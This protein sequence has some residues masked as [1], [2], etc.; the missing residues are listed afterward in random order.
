VNRKWRAYLAGLAGSGLIAYFVLGLFDG[1]A[2][3]HGRELLAARRPGRRASGQALAEA[4]G[5]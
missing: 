1:S 3:G 2:A 5:T 4:I